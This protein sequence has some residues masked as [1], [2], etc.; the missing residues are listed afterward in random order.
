MTTVLWKQRRRKVVGK[1]QSGQ[2]TRVLTNSRHKIAKSVRRSLIV[3]PEVIA[4]EPLRRGGFEE[5]GAEKEIKIDLTSTKHL[6]ALSRGIVPVTEGLDVNEGVW[7]LPAITRT[8][9]FTYSARHSIDRDSQTLFQSQTEILHGNSGEDGSLFSRGSTPQ[10]GDVQS[11]PVNAS[12]VHNAPKEHRKGKIISYLF[13]MRGL[14]DAFHGGPNGDCFTEFGGLTHFTS[15]ENVIGDLY[16]KTAPP[17]NAILPTLVRSM[18]APDAMDDVSIEMDDANGNDSDNENFSSEDSVS[19]GETAPRGHLVLSTLVRSAAAP[20]AMDQV[21][22]VNGRKDK[23]TGE[24]SD[25]DNLSSDESISYGETAAAIV[26]LTPFSPVTASLAEFEPAGPIR[27][28]KNRGRH[29]GSLP[30]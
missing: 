11:R 15:S 14:D 21:S 7:I 29:N 28:Q 12:R 9:P 10:G 3:E 24:V 17:A 25:K 16:E 13:G 18:P 6:T 8:R 19:C 2:S 4:D 5:N 22:I 23:T 30:T 1:S 20:N 27:L 26:A